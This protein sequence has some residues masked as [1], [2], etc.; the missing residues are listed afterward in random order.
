[1]TC[2]WNV[3]LTRV[4]TP[5]QGSRNG[6]KAAPAPSTQPDSPE[7]EEPEL[8]LLAC[9]LW[10]AAAAALIALLSEQLVGAIEEAAVG[11]RV[12]L[13]FLSTI[14][15]PI[16]GNA[17]EHASAITFAA[18]GRMELVMGVAVGTLI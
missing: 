2:H 3:Q 7:A 10:L 14:L 16:V 13:P 4:G 17:A 8:S 1:M 11:L 18:K 12:P 6:S 15:L 5:V 9:V